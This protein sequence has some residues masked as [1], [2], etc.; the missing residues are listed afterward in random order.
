MKQ[1]NWNKKYLVAVSGGPDSIFLLSQI[2]S[3][4][5][6]NPKN[7]IVCHVNYNYRNDSSI[8]ERIVKNICDQNKIKLETKILKIDYDNLNV[9]FE[10]FAREQRYDFFVKVQKNNPDF[11]TVLVAHN[12]NDLIETYLI[13]KERKGIVN[14]FG[15]KSETEYKNLKV[16]RPIINIKK[17]EI[18]NFLHKGK[19]EYANDS[20]NLDDKFLRNKIRKQTNEEEFKKIVEEINKKNVMLEKNNL[21]AEKYLRDFSSHNHLKLDGFENLNSNT[22]QTVIAWFLIK[23]QFKETLTNNKK[24]LV[25]EIVKIS[26]SKKPF[27]L[28]KK[29]DLVIL[30][31]FQDLY[32]LEADLL[33]SEIISIKDEN[34]ISQKW[35][36]KF[37]EEISELNISKDCF[38]TNDYFLAKKMRL[39]NNKKLVK[40]F[41]ETKT[42]YYNRVQKRYILNKNKTI[43]LYIL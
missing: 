14:Y 32:L 12:L 23:S 10:S 11:D 5:Q 33:K 39:E 13:Q 36:K 29:Q 28:I 20:T 15:L 37:L 3:N 27:V 2:I 19:V 9:N 7:F 31:D 30:K 4:K 34:K 35:G 17:S 6:F 22:I 1:I 42:S 41:S 43:I 21:T 25:L 18:L 38:V 26:Q 8:D 40:C 24:S 16:V